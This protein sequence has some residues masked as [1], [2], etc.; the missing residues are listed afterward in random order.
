MGVFF[1]GFFLGGCCI[2]LLF[3]SQLIVKRL[4]L[5]MQLY[6][7]INH[8]HVSRVDTSNNYLSYYQV[9]YQLP[10]T[11]TGGQSTELYTLLTDQMGVRFRVFFH[12]LKYNNL[13]LKDD[14]S[15][16]PQCQHHRQLRLQ[17]RQILLRHLLTSHSSRRLLFFLILHSLSSAVSLMPSSINATATTKVSTQTTE[18]TKGGDS[19]DKRCCRICG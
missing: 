19:A 18:S 13:A 2:L 11:P 5:I 4:V 6:F 16:T 3:L 7:R 14:W 9:G 12:L 17:S 8:F 15:V 1:W 10:F